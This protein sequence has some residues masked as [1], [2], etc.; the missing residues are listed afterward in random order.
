MDFVQKPLQTS[1]ALS[2]FSEVTSDHL[3]LLDMKQD[4]T[5]SICSRIGKVL[6]YA[7]NSQPHVS[8]FGQA[9]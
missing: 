8:Q 1:D 2:I 6:A 7:A 9:G 3:P 4:I 5:I